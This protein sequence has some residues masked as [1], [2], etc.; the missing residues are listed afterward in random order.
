[1]PI[2]PGHKVTGLDPAP[3]GE[4][5]YQESRY[6]VD[7]IWRMGTIGTQRRVLV[8]GPR[9][10]AKVVVPDFVEALSS[11]DA[12]SGAFEDCEDLR[13]VVLPDGL[14]VIGWWAFG[15]C[16]ALATAV[17]PPSVKEI[18][19]YAFQQCGALADIGPLAHGVKLHDASFVGC[20]SLP[21]A[22]RARIEEINP[23][24]LLPPPVPGSEA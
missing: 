13:E 21:D 4:G 22:T 23:G 5:D 12:E 19:P 14:G 6:L 17:I 9:G 15:G 11:L 24:A 3:F 10:Q 16:A 2:I 1:M 20:G 8:R 18:H 7:G